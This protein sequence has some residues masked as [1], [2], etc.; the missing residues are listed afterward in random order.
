MKIT[1]AMVLC[2]G[3]GKRLRPLTSSNPKPLLEIGNKTLLSNTLDILRQFGIKQVVLNLHYL[4]DKIVDYVKSNEFNLK[5]TTVVEKDKIL[6]TGG[7]V[8][9]AIKYFSNETFLIIN[10]DTIWNTQHL[11]ELKLME[12]NFFSNEKR[13]CSLLVVKKEKSFDQNLKEISV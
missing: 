4:G 1:K 8:L 13:K 6:D 10:P 11:K 9:N 2:A 12:K 3:F 7:G 5:V